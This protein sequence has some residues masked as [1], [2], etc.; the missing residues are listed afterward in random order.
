MPFDGSDIPETARV[1]DALLEFFGPEGERWIQEHPWNKKGNRC[2]WGALRFTKCSLTA[3]RQAERQ[4]AVAIDRLFPPTD[5][6]ATNSEIIIR[7]NDQIAQRYQD[8]RYVLL[9]ARADIMKSGATMG[10][11]EIERRKHVAAAIADSRIEGLPP[12]DGA[13]LEIFEAYI[14]GEIDAGDL[15]EVYKAMFEAMPG[16]RP[17]KGD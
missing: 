9:M 2:L 3:R 15:V 13:E 11:A 10:D 4:I 7:Y 8:I 12:P 6:N 17:V 14:R 1:I 5:A 16:K